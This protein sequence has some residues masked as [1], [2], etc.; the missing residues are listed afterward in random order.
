M[1]KRESEKK[2]PEKLILTKKQF[3]KLVP[4]FVVLLVA[5]T[6]VV[7]GM[8]ARDFWQG[9]GYTFLL[10][11]I[12]RRCIIQGVIWIWYKRV[13]NNGVVNTTEDS[14]FFAKGI[15]ASVGLGIIIAM[16]VGSM[17]YLAG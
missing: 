13:Q 10:W 17:I 7:Y 11:I 15:L 12:L 14:N 9:F 2:E 16:I 3:V 4:V 5:L 6:G 1:K 8:G